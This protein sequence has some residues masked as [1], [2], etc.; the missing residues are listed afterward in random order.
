MNAI[1]FAV[2][3]PKCRFVCILPKRHLNTEN[4]MSKCESIGLIFPSQNHENAFLR[5]HSGP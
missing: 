2:E 5:K 3:T 4:Q 1:N